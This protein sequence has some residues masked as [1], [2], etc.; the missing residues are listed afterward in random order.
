MSI[1]HGK[2]GNVYWDSQGTDTVV[3]QIQ[4]WSLDVTHDIAE[5]T[6]M[7][8]TWKTYR[9]GFQD[10]TASVVCLLPL[11]G[12]DLPVEADGT[13]Q[14]LGDVTAARLEL[15]VVWDTGTPLY[16]LL[17][18]NGFV[19]G[20]EYGSDRNEA[21]TITYTFQGSGQMQWASGAARP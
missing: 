6:S 9:T 7:Q 4:S 21:P 20:I 5:A 17:Y 19:T 10:W 11:A 2:D 14:S 15:Y 8:D 18:G 3:T 16:K 13:P 1:L 12:G